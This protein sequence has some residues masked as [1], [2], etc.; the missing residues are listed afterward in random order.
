MC[1]HIK[2]LQGRLIVA[3]QRTGVCRN[4]KYCILH[5]RSFS[6]SKNAYTQKKNFV[7]LAA[8]RSLPINSLMYDIKVPYLSRIDSQ[9]S[10]DSISAALDEVERY[11]IG[12]TPWPAFT[13][14]PDVSF[15]VAYTSDNIAIKYYVREKSLRGLYALA[16]TPVHEDSCLEFFISFD[17]EPAYYN[18]EL[19]CI[20]TCS[21]GY[22]K[23]KEL[24]QAIP[25]EV[26][27][28]IKRH[29]MIE[30]TADGDKDAVYWELLVMIPMEVFIYHDI[31]NLQGRQCRV[32]FFKCGD[33]LPEPH[34]LAWKNIIAATPNFHLPE[35][36]GIMH[37][38]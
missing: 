22:G 25:G 5:G 28:K 1:D 36:F 12:T 3:A 29:I 37:F 32:N 26:I 14:K 24:R 8:L 21:F 18:L 9:A 30:H 7:L 2:R 6:N 34:F 31:Q 19:N 15:S 27:S 33:E 35:F 38:D 20:G 17:D 11:A 23:D 13:Y 10:L 4:K 16:N